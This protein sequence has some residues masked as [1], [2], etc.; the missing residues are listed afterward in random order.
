MGNMMMKDSA[1][2][3]NVDACDD[4]KAEIQRKTPIRSNQLERKTVE[5]PTQRRNLLS[6]MNKVVRR[7]SRAEKNRTRSAEEQIRREQLE[8]ETSSDSITADAIKSTSWCKEPSWLRSNQLSKAEAEF[9]SRIGQNDKQSDLNTTL[10][11]LLF[12]VQIDF[13]TS[14]HF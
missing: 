13:V 7:S 4:V 2:V 8:V 11:K 9:K 3:N 5:K 10:R 14:R 12:S 6:M 1:S